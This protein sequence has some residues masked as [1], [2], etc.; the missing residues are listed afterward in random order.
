[1]TPYFNNSEFKGHQLMIDY[2][3][4][5]AKGSE[6]AA[7]ALQPFVEN[8]LLEMNQKRELQ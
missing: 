2:C 8:I 3:H 5:S 7:E 4:L 1:M 6:V